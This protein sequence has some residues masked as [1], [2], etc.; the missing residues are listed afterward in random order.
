MKNKVLII[1]FSS[2]GD[3]VQCSTVVDYIYQQTNG[4][5]EID[6]ITRKEFEGLVSL[7]SKINKVIA[8]DRKI[9][10]VGLIKLAYQLSLENYDLIY[11][12]HNN[13]RSNIIK[14]LFILFSSSTCIITRSKDRLKRVMLFNFRINFFEVPFKGIHSYI[15]PLKKFFESKNSEVK[16]QE[17]KTD[18]NFT[19]VLLPLNLNEKLKNVVLVPSAAWEMKRWP[20]ENWLKLSML[21]KNNQIYV[22]G[23][24]EDTF[25]EEFSKLNIENIQN[26]AGKLSLIESCKLISKADLIISGDTGLL[27]VADVLDKKGLSIMGPT[28]FGFTSSSNIK[29][30]EV[31]LEC[32]PCTKD[33]SGKCHQNIYKKCLVEITP[34][35]VYK[36]ALKK[37]E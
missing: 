30:I 15:K 6:W 13:I 18:Y 11:D 9:G 24:R 14:L 33:G 16:N 35:L 34:E 17:I 21:L 29:T 23:G 8:F 37:L 20:L 25:C 26:L 28:A 12:A 22:L 7:N 1:R 5:V 3:I 31:P 27:H 19:K 10:F 2:F 36:E 4:L 32:R